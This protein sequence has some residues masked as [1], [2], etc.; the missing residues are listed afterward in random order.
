MDEMD[1]EGA[2]T[3]EHDE[4]EEEEGEQK[5]DDEETKE[6]IKEETDRDDEYLQEEEDKKDIE[7][8]GNG[9]KGKKI[10]SHLGCLQNPLRERP[11]LPSLLSAPQSS[12]KEKGR[13]RPH[14]ISEQERA[15]E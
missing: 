8:E 1:E 7:E 5:E 6:E 9:T 2:D 4:Y 3:E 12:K 14:Y 10:R 15:Q 13:G 11:Q